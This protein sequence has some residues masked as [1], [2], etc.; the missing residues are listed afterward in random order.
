[1]SNNDISNKGNPEE[2]I[3]FKDD[4]E[5]PTSVEHKSERSKVI[6]N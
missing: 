3:L 5:N 4:E 2:Y 1:M 6:I